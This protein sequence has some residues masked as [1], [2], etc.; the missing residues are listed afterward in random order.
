[1]NDVTSP[2][3]ELDAIVGYDAHR[4]ERW[5]L[6]RIVAGLRGGTLALLKRGTLSALV[7]RREWGGLLVAGCK[8]LTSDTEQSSLFRR[9]LDLNYF[10]TRKHMKLWVFWPRMLEDRAESCHKRGAP[11][12][13]PGYRR[14]LELAGITRRR[15]PPDYD[16]P[17][18]PVEPEPLPIEVAALIERVKDLQK[19]NRLLHE[20]LEISSEVD[21]ALRQVLASRYGKS[22]HNHPAAR[23][24]SRLSRAD[25]QGR[26]GQRAGR[27][28]RNRLS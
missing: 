14:C 23:C 8:L 16:P 25:A 10:D 6:D 17:P 12:I 15:D 26:G 28:L 13:V 5:N 11:F 18:P 4:Y 3:A 24:R 19:Q 21:D 2:A 1:M 9:V 20:A 7:A 27:S 22:W